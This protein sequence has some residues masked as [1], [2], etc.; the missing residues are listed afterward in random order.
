RG[1]RVRVSTENVGLAR[2]AEGTELVRIGKPLR[3]EFAAWRYGEQLER[4]LRRAWLTAASVASVA[5]AGIA[6]A[7]LVAPPVGLFAA[8]FPLALFR[9][10]HRHTRPEHDLLRA[11]EALRDGAGEPIMGTGRSIC[12]ARLR[13]G[14]E[15]ESGWA[16]ELQTSRYE[17]TDPNSELMRL[18]STHLLL[19]DPRTHLLAGAPAL[20][21]ATVLLAHANLHG[22]TH[23]AVKGAVARLDRSGGPRAYFLRAEAEARREGWGYRELWAM[24][25]EIRLA[26]EMATHEDSE[27]RALE[28]ELAELEAYWRDA[29]AIAAVADRLAIPA[30]VERAPPPPR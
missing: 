23:E 13:T 18:P 30:G 15:H 6:G 19:V 26:L 1:T 2:L 25:F 29:E 16:L 11:A 22:A 10:W 5:A 27:R 14:D 9:W 12:R 3:P 8:G 20:R 17:P 21:A 28:G 4:R 24:P 7:A